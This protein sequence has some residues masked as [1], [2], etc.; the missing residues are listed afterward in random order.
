MAVPHPRCYFLAAQLQ[1]LG[2]GID[3][4]GDNNGGIVTAGTPHKSVLE[5]LEANSFAYRTPTIK[6]ITK[7]WKSIKALKGMGGETRFTPLWD[8]KNL[9]ELI[10]IGK[11]RI[12]ETKG[13]V[14][15][16]Q[17]YNGST[18][19]TF[20]S[21]KEEFDVPNHSYYNY[22]QIRHALRAQ[23]GEPG[24]SWSL[25]PILQRLCSSDGSGGFIAEM[26]PH[27]CK[28]SMEGPEKLKCRRK[29]EEDLGTI[30]DEQWIKVLGGRA[31]GLAFTRPEILTPN[32]A[33]QGISYP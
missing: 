3:P 24:P 31:S 28:G 8:N 16:V 29:W 19:K 1:H 21:L 20:S 14:K 27:I 12:W 6:L 22:L 25:S 2:S 23:F 17:L 9:Q 32:A 10:Q 5:A 30:P 26:Y 33:T 18:L 11:I 13:I 4:V 15:L 7:V